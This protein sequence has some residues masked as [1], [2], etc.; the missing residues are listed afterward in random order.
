MKMLSQHTNIGELPVNWCNADAA[1]SSVME[2][3]SFVTPVLENFFIRTVVEGI[4]IPRDGELAER[5]QAFIR[6]ESNHS[7]VH[8]KFNASLL[9][10]LGKQPPGL[11]MVGWLLESARQRLS[12]SKR[13]ALAAALEHLA[14]VISK[15][16]V[17]QE[18]KL[19][20]SSAYARELFD[21]HA[22][23]ELAHRSVVFDLW[24]DNGASSRISRLVTITL[25]LGAGAAYVSI[26]VP[27]I[28]H[29][30][31]GR[32]FI[33][34]WA[35]LTNFVVKNF[36]DTLVHTPIVELFSFVR[37]DYH[38]ESLIDDAHTTEAR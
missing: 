37:H 24:L 20:F 31:T 7:L 18:D 25:V 22:R 27:W 33:R 14:A 12:I 28:L 36:K 16:Y 19:N 38:P 2:A 8:K 1:T 4:R 11:A 35:C 15:L 5:C 23:E 3:V 9:A 32:R 29:Q 26:A 17:N 13:L 30:K 6:E 10:H 21:M 34:T